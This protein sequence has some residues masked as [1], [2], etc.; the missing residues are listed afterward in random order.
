MGTDTFITALE[1]LPFEKSVWAI[2]IFTSEKL[3]YRDYPDLS[4]DS[5]PSYHKGMEDDKKEKEID[6]S[7]AYDPEDE[8]VF[9][10]AGRAEGMSFDDD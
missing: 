7:Q 10:W 3:T 8:I 4:R 2:L 5:I 6:P 9:E 1:T